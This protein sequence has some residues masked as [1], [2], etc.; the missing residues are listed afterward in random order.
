MHNL[1]N[2][3]HKLSWRMIHI[4]FYGTLPYNIGQKTRPYD[5]QKRKKNGK[6]RRTCKIVD[7]AVLDDHRITL[8]ESEKKDKFLNLA[9]ELKKTVEHE[10][11][12]YTKHD[13][14]IWYCYQMII[15]GIGRLG[16]KKTTGDRP[17]YYIIGNDQNTDKSPGELR[18]LAITQ[19]PLKDYQ[20]TLMGKKLSRSK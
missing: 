6:K 1:E 8:K 5:N 12:N 4:N 10:S 18:R 15:K 2:D 16:N 9:W 7:F 17:N 3:T 19:T 13:W 14:C 11:D 20:L